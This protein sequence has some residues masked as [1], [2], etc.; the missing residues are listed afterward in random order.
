VRRVSFDID[1]DLAALL[2]A[3]AADAKL[4]E[5]E[6]VERALRAMDLRVLVARIRSRSDLDEDAAV[7]LV[8][9][10]LAAARAERAA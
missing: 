8:A 4:S 1:D 9:E 7:Q 10:E 2:T 6:V 3:T 5:S